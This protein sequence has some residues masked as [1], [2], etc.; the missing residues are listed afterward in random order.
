MS[1]LRW[2]ATSGSIVALLLATVV[3]IVM[4]P[5]VQ[6]S[7]SVALDL[8]ASVGTLWAAVVGYENLKEISA[9]R[10][11]EVSPLIR[12]HLTFDAWRGVVTRIVNL[13]KGSAADVRVRAWV[14]ADDGHTVPSEISDQPQQLKAGEVSEF[15]TWGL[16]VDRLKQGPAYV[17]VTYLE[18]IKETP[19]RIC[20]R[21]GIGADGTF[22]T[23]RSATPSHER[24]VAAL[25]Q[26]ATLMNQR[27]PEVSALSFAVDRQ[28]VRLNALVNGTVR[29]IDYPELQNLEAI[30][31]AALDFC[32]KQLHA[33]D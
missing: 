24:R 26:L 6:F 32:A 9:A 19:A 22:S 15:S 17:E 30:S 4:L 3:P 12:V 1:R 20:F 7:P 10:V 2:I 5:A 16:T 13:G 8:F 25:E 33:P 23:E 11:A 31:S 14:T 28:S 18:A 21:L 29:R 27:V